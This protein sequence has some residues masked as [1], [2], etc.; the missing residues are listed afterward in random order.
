VSEKALRK[1][2]KAI[3]K[4]ARRE[5]WLG[6]KGPT[7][8]WPS[9]IREAKYDR[10]WSWGSNVT[11]TLSPEVELGGHRM[12]VCVS[13]NGSEDGHNVRVFCDD[14]VKH[15]GG[16]YEQKREWFEGWSWRLARME[17]AEGGLTGPVDRQDLLLAEAHQKARGV[18]TTHEE[19]TYCR[20]CGEAVEE[21]DGIA[22]E[23]P[24]DPKEQSPWPLP[25]TKTDSR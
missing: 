18:V 25:P 11:W 12:R 5:V 4:L 8:V 14:E 6:G 1:L 9:E 24:L 16:K 7:K 13:W 15:P 10:A 3:Y 22:P 21:V 20:L 19:P 17:R 23:I 2:A